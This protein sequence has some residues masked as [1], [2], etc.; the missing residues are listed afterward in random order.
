MLQ[1][2]LFTFN[3]FQENTYVI[4]NNKKQCWIVDPGMNYEDENETLI[5]FINENQL[6][7]Q[8]IIN[9]HTHIDHIFGVQYLID[10]YKI[11]FGIHKGEI[12]LLNSCIK[13][14]AMFGIK[15]N[16]IPQ[17]TFFIVEEESF[18]LGDEQLKVLLCPGHSPASIVFYYPKG[19]WAIT[20]DVLFA[21]SIGRTDLPGGSFETLINSIKSKLVLLPDDTVIYPGHGGSSTIGEE[22]ATNPFLVNS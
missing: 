2:Q 12:P 22:K 6:V 7:P 19:K 4:Y 18:L 10:K 5:A 11:G 9:T 3:P 1:I 20:G 21:G 15:F 13:S 16:H 17:P 8:S 14:A